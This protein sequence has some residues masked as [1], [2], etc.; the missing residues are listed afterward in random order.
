[1]KKKLSS[2]CMATAIAITGATSVSAIDLPIGESNDLDALD[3]LISASLCMNT[4]SEDMWPSHVQI[5][6]LVPLYSPSGDKVAWYLTLISGE[7]AVVHNDKDNPGVIEFGEGDNHLIQEILDT[8]SNAR[9]VYNSPC[10][11]YEYS[12]NV[13]S[14]IDMNTADIYSYYP[15]L[16]SS[17][18]E[19]QEK[20]SAY[21]F[22]VINKY[23]EFI[24]PYAS[25]EDYGFINWDD[26]PS[27]T[28][29]YDRISI[30]GIDWAIMNDYND[31]ANN[32][33]GTTTMTNIA[34]YYAS[35]GYPD[36][37][38]NGNKD[39]T[40]RVMHNYIP[41]GPQFDL[42]S[43]AQD[44]FSE[45]C[46]YNLYYDTT[47]GSFTEMKEAIRN[48]HPLAVLLINHLFS[49][50]WVVG[51]GYRE[52]HLVDGMNYLQIVNNWENT[53]NKFYLIDSG[54]TLQSATEY[55][56]E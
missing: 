46:G 10:D 32:H 11:V 53:A 9:I 55:W 40:F 29:F 27:S 2:L 49:M 51:V 31:I 39:D 25:D 33:C 34:I 50:H 54:S 41:N 17:D 24:I 6:E 13:S 28:Y 43:K 52:Y 16:K 47:Y 21:K 18:I 38:Q 4:A 20:T 56:L 36:A 48:N 44:Y 42:A 35:N 22:D 45:E 12:Y 19:L 23:S 8:N 15:T 14:S 3:V 1:M 37:M 5:D 26:M 30:S 7:Y